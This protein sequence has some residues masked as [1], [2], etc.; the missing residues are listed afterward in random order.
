MAQFLAL[1]FTIPEDEWMYRIVDGEFV[2]S[3]ARMIMACVLAASLCQPTGARAA[4]HQSALWLGVNI[5]GNLGSGPEW[6][7]WRYRVQLQARGFDALEGTRQAI[8][9]IGLSRRLP[10]GFTV[11]GGYRYFHTDSTAAGTFHENRLWQQLNWTTGGWGRSTFRWRTRLEQ[12]F[13]DERSGTGLRFRQQFRWD[14][15]ISSWDGVDFIIGAEP[16]FELRD[17][18]WTEA[19]FTQYRTFLGIATAINPQLR[20]EAGYM[21]L[22]ISRRQGRDFNNHVFIANFSFR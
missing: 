17:T 11:S 10:K 21:H 16:F 8:A 6:S 5:D 3:S 7:D 13:V 12:R 20:L 4:E 9:G 22:V 1:R 15:P 2:K 14:V 18:E 19:G